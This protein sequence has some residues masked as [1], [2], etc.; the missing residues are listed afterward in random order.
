MVV[1]KVS[2]SKYDIRGHSTASEMVPFDM[3]HPIYY[4]SFIAIMLLYCTVNEIL[5]IISQHLK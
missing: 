5:S 1:R 3:P 4:K 2:N